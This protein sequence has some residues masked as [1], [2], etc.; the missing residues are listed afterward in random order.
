MKIV[1][2]V[3]A[4]DE[5]KKFKGAKKGKSKSGG[6]SEKRDA[7][8]KRE[9]NEKQKQLLEKLKKEGKHTESTKESTSQ[10]CES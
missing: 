7:N 5:E 4:K 10:E 9:L 1:R 8:K 3:Q 6:D 2:D